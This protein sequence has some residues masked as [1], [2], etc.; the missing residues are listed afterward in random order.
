MIVYHFKE[1]YIGVR[2]GNI[3]IILYYKMINNKNGR[4]EIFLQTYNF[5]RKIGCIKLVPRKL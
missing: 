1:G 2:L 5:P 3:A 4:P